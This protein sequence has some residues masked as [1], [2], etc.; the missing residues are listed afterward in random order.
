VEDIFAGWVGD[1]MGVVRGWVKMEY[2]YCK[3]ERESGW[4]RVGMEIKSVAWVGMGV[5]SV[6]MQV[7]IMNVIFIHLCYI[8]HTMFVVLLFDRLFV[9]VF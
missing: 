4:G 3:D 8:I 9:A 1:G 6:P 5:I 7:S 2:K